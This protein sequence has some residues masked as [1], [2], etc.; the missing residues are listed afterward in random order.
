MGRRGS[1]GRVGRLG[2]QFD[3]LVLDRA[4]AE[5]HDDRG[6]LVRQPD[7]LD[8]ADGRRLGLGTDDHRRVAGEVGE[9]VA[10]AQQHLLEPAVGRREERPHLARSSRRRGGRAPRG[11]R[12]RTGTPCRSG[13]GRPTC[14]AGRGSP[15]ARAPPSRCARSPTT[16][17]R[18]ARRRCAWNRR[19]APS[20]C[21]PARRRRGS[22]SSVRPASW[23]S[24]LPSANASQWSP[25]MPAWNRCPSSPSETGAEEARGSQMFRSLR[26][27]NAK[28]FFAGLAVS[29][30]GTWL[31]ATAQVLLVRRLGGNG[32][33]LGIVTAC[34]FLPMLAHRSVGRR[35]GRPV[36]PPAADDHHPG[37]DG[38]P[39][40]RPRR[41]R[42][43]RRRD[44]PDRVRD[45]AGARHH[46]R[47]RQPGA[48]RARHRARRASPPHER[49]VAEHLGHDRL[50][51]LRPG[52]RRAVRQRAGHRLVL[53]AQR[54]VVPRPAVGV[55][56][57][58]P[59]PPVPQR[60]GGRRATRRFATASERCGPIP[61]CASP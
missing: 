49:D 3:D 43:H 42:P 45:V 24:R 31:Q 37:G 57:D 40:H 23:Q 36:R 33:A 35:V 15:P 46:R 25:S 54:C 4:V 56:G 7:E 32:L 26:E 51:D 47:D 39:G 12:R 21:I 30:V 13:S 28:L 41:A 2:R 59:R 52:P 18:R 34:Q 55:G 8:A 29:N 61:C 44:D 5:D 9:Q 10:R 11:G 53:R 38:R 58:R 19:A 16:P 14:A 20:R 60:A 1:D 27:R 50:A 6:V 17:R 22:P 48:A